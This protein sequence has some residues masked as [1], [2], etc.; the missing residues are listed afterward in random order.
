MTKIIYIYIDEACEKINYEF[1]IYG[2]K[3]RKK[4]NDNVLNN[5]TKLSVEIWSIDQISP[6]GFNKLDQ[7]VNN[8]AN[9]SFFLLHEWK[10]LIYKPLVGHYKFYN[11]KVHSI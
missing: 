5:G 10:N 3:I 11:F 7:I 8:L 9:W 4:K 1:T 6:Y 2:T